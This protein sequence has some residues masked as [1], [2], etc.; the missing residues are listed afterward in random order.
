ML[1]YKRNYRRFVLKRVLLKIKK[2]IALL[3]V[4]TIL[5]NHILL[6]F[7]G[8]QATTTLLEDMVSSNTIAEDDKTDIDEGTNKTIRKYLLTKFE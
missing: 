1:E 3:F 4:F 7:D 8:V 6:I 5:Q 2:I